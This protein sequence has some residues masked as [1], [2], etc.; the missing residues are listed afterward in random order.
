MNYTQTAASIFNR[1][2]KVY[3]FFLNFFTVGAINR[4]QKELVE[5][6]PDKEKVLDIG[7]G[8]GEVLKKTKE[9]NPESLCIGIDLSFN[10]LKIA[11]NKLKNYKNV[12]FINA[13]IYKS[14]FKDKS[15]N[16]VFLSLTY[17]HLEHEKLINEI[18]RILEYGGY[19]SIFDTGRL[20][21]KKI[22]NLFLFLVNRV[23]RPVGLIFFTKEEYDYFVDSLYKSVTFEELIERFKKDNFQL[24][25]SKK[26]F[27]GLAFICVWRRG[28]DSN[29][30]RAVNPQVISNHPPSSARPPLL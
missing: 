22:W 17:R 14:P 13:D 24:I 21:N 9:T 20:K 5:K 3:D 12:Y 19:I 29:P 11:Q 18:K 16:A 1:I 28:R 2:S 7:T 15:F 27:G 6:T 4:W 30:R 23:F 25:Y 26:I 8:T 10:M